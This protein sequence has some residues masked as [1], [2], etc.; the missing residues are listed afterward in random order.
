MNCL[1]PSAC[2]HSE[3]R[4]RPR[5][6]Q[7]FPA[8][9]L[10]LSG[11]A[12]QAS[13]YGLRPLYP[14]ARLTFSNAEV[15]FVPVDSLQPTLRWETFPPS[16]ARIGEDLPEPTGPVCYDLRIWRAATDERPAE[17]VYERGGLPEPSHRPELRLEP[18]T[19]YLWSVRARFPTVAGD[20]VSEWSK[21][22]K[23][24]LRRSNVVPEINCYRFETPAATTP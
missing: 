23:R 1:P 15:D 17:L 5:H 2:T 20:R 19:H 6:F 11:C 12:Q 13:V 4:G 21:P 18:E 24:N 8:L 7:L 22:H 10:V 16:N 9:C 3:C 14:E